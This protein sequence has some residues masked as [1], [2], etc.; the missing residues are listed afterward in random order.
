MYL[1]QIIESP[2]NHKKYRA[3]IYEKKSY[4]NRRGRKL[5]DIDFGDN[6]Y[7]D[8]TQHKDR[9][10]KLDYLKRNQYQKENGWWDLTTENLSRPAWWSR[11]FSWSYPSKS[12]AKEFISNIMRIDFI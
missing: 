12:E 2:R 10:R 9:E 6:R 7:E 5:Y 11:Y 1:V 8:Y 4:S 3:V